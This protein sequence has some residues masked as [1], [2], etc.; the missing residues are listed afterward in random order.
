MKDIFKTSGLKSIGHG[1]L[2]CPC[3]N[4]FRTHGNHST[5][6]NTFNKLR[7]SRLHQELVKELKYDLL[8]D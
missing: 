3:C 5:K 2:R 1:G 4:E 7:R 8:K 6:D